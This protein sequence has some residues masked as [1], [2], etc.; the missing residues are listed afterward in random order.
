MIT[1]ED[2]INEVVTN[3][4]VVL[5]PSPIEG[6]GVFAIRDIPKGTRTMFSKSSPND[7][8]ITI[9]QNEVASLPEF[10]RGIIYNYCLFD[11]HNYFLP[12]QGFKQMD[13]SLYL[14]HSDHPNIVSI[15]D[16]ECF[17]A[18]RDIDAGEELVIDYETIV[19]DAG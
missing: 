19:H 17:E 10:A 4:F 13:L 11:E 1:K 8:W 5:R 15:N 12:E 18:I 9:S 6:V 7:R 16:G 2:L 3:T 14:N